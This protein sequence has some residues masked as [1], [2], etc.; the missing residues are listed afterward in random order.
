MAE[1]PRRIP[2]PLPVEDGYVPPEKSKRGMRIFLVA[3]GAV[4]LACGGAL[5]WSA[6]NRSEPPR[7]VERL[8]EL[9]IGTCFDWSEH[10]GSMNVPVVNCNRPHDAQ[11]MARHIVDDRAAWPGEAWFEEE[12]GPRCERTL[13]NY[14][15]DAYDDPAI[16]VGWVATD[17]VGWRQGHRWVSCVAGDSVNKRSEPLH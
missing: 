12:Y 4:L 7:N 3:L 6:A 13:R 10:E 16:E 14:A 15:P 1:P 8:G 2:A 11:V 5:A 9:G 17:E